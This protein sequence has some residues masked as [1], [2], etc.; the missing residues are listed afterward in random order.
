MGV[1]ATAVVQ[2]VA[3]QLVNTVKQVGVTATAVV[4]DVATQL[5]NT[6]D[7][8]GVMANTVSSPLPVNRWVISP[9]SSILLWWRFG[10]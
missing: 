5:V 2:D 10:T 6:V 4:Q 7:K 1:I 8:V 9:Q 3:T